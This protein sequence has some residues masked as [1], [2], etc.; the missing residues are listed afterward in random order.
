VRYVDRAVTVLD[1]KLTGKTVVTLHTYVQNI[2]SQCDMLQWNY[3]YMSEGGMISV[4]VCLP[5]F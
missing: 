1:A 3:V 5:S 4:V 2:P